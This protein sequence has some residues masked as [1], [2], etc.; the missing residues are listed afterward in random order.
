[1]DELLLC[2]LEAVLELE[3]RQ[4]ALGGNQQPRREGVEHPY[5]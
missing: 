2:R 1:M 4:S 3:G 5:F